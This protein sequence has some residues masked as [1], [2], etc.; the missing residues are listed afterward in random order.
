MKK[1]IWIVF[2]F[3]L[4]ENLRGIMTTKSHTKIAVTKL[5][6][7]IITSLH[8]VEVSALVEVAQVL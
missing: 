5:K 7:K 3:I 6:N 2:I 8:E 1:M 4:L